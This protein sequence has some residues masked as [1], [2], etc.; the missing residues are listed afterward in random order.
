MET[1][2]WRAGTEALPVRWRFARPGA[3]QGGAAAALSAW[4]LQR[5]L[6]F[7]S[8]TSGGVLRTDFHCVHVVEALGGAGPRFN[9][10]IC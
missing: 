7:H 3:A 4:E 1:Q 9:W 6:P 10:L 8:R 2:S 5:K